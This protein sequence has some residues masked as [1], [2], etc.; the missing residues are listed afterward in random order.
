MSNEKSFWKKIL[1]GRLM[2]VLVILVIFFGIVVLMDRV[3][4]PYYVHLGDEMQMP[5]VVEM[6]V[7][8]AKDFLEK[9]GFDVII[10]DSVYDAYLAKGTVVEQNP[11][12]YSTVKKGRNVY[13]TVSIGEKPIIMPNLFNKS[14]RQAELLLQQ[15]GLELESKFYDYSDISPEGVVIAQSYPQGQKIKKDAK[16]SITISL[17]AMPQRQVIPDLVGQSLGAAKK[18]LQVLGINTINIDYEEKENMLPETVLSQS[19]PAGQQIGHQ[20]SISLKV[21]KIKQFDEPDE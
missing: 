1:S 19:L 17:G 11:L 12:S 5:E 6:N 20:D 8:E 9:Q 21:S 16:V 2:K 15:H 3:V 14:P 13:L 4:M 18:Q 7:N 10:A